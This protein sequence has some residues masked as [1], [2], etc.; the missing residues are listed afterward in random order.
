MSSLAM[1]CPPRP[2]GCQVSIFAKVINAVPNAT[3]LLNDWLADSYSVVS[4]FDD[5]FAHR[6]V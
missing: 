5:A 2:F 3:F 1:T 4:L 6:V